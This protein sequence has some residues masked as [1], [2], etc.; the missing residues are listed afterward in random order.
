MNIPNSQ[1]LETL[2]YE[3]ATKLLKI[4]RSTLHNAT[5]KGVLTPLPRRARKPGLLPRKQVELFI[6]KDL[7]LR[8]LSPSEALVWQEQALAV[9]TQ[10]GQA[11]KSQALSAA[12][13]GQ[14]VDKIAFT[15]ALLE[16]SSELILQVLIEEMTD[17]Y[18]TS[19]D[20]T[21]AKLF[22][23]SPYFRRLA[24]LTGIDTASLDEDTARLL[25]VE[26]QRIVGNFLQRVGALILSGF[27]TLIN[28]D[29]P[30]KVRSALMEMVEEY[31]QKKETT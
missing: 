24:A 30:A 10:T 19:E 4:S 3:E 20:D 9:Q 14:L 2:T 25:S 6:G 31:R 15:V 16:G 1:E 13:R 7:S 26:V 23:V 8:W 27:K 22:L 12:D 28:E 18:N 5:S 17:V 29:E 21:F 11:A